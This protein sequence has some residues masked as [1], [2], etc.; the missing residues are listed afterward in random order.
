MNSV[1]SSLIEVLRE[2]GPVGVSTFIGGLI[3]LTKFANEN[4]LNRQILF[5]LL[6]LILISLSVYIAYFRL[7][8]QKDREKAYI[9]MAE[10]TCNRL[11]E[12]LSKNMNDHQVDAIIQKIRQTQKD[13]IESVNDKK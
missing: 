5:G 2:F 13:L 7:K 9:M 6:G 12:Q 8:I 4:L 10:S 11:A 1:E 3:L